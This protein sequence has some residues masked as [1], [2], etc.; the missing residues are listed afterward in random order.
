[1]SDYLT[2]DQDEYKRFLA[3]NKPDSGEKIKLPTKSSDELNIISEFVKK[4]ETIGGKLNRKPYR[5][6]GKG[7]WTI[8]VGHELK[9]QN[10]IPNEWTDE[11]INNQFKEDIT[12]KRFVN[13][14]I[15]FP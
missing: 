9:N 10:R 6:G 8:G 15:F 3:I 13:S 7:N 5:V 1:M 11:H 4:N 14:F 2:F 12:E